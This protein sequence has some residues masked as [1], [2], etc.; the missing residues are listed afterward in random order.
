MNYFDS[1]QANYST[2][3]FLYEIGQNLSRGLEHPIIML[4]FKVCR[5]I[6]LL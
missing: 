1:M 4:Y 3:K 5:L 2:L 6:T